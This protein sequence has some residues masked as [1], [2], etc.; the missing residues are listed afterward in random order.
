MVNAAFE[1]R[2]LSDIDDQAETFQFTGL[3]HLTWKDERQA[4]DP[5][6]TGAQEVVFQGSYQFN[7]L[8]PAWYPEV[9]L[10]N[11]AGMYE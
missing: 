5:A 8:A 10:A 7:E 9:A 3:L 11:A 4:F 2:E 6:V 1:F